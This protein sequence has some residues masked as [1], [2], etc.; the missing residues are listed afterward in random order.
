[1]AWIT[2][3]IYIYIWYLCLRQLLLP[4]LRSL[5]HYVG[6]PN[7]LYDYAE[8]SHLRLGGGG[9]FFLTEKITSIACLFISGL[10]TIFHWWAQIVTVCKSFTGFTWVSATS[11]N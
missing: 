8:H 10:N 6:K 1:M 5:K 3:Y 9:M 11:E 4:A 7:D 2:L